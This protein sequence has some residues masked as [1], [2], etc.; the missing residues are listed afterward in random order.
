MN[1]IYYLHAKE[2]LQMK[3]N[4]KLIIGIA[5]IIVGLGGATREVDTVWHY[6][7]TGTVFG[8]GLSLSVIEIKKMLK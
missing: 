8:I 6:F 5:L 7:G 1:I 4:L 2:L 3:L